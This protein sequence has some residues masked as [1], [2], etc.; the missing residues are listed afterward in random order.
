[1]LFKLMYWY[2]LRPLLILSLPTS[3][4]KAVCHNRYSAQILYRHYICGQTVFQM[5]CH[6]HS[7]QRYHTMLHYAIPLIQLEPEEEEFPQEKWL[8][9][10]KVVVVWFKQCKIHSL[11]IS[12]IAIL[13]YFL[14]LYLWYIWD[15]LS[16]RTGKMAVEYVELCP[17][18]SLAY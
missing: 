5:I 17:Y 2:C 3:M 1:M 15:L 4:Q 13:K 11:N 8:I 7:M 16:Q 9:E 6:I 18:N 10:A 12:A 14:F